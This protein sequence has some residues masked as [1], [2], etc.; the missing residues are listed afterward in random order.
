[1]KRLRP[2]LVSLL[3]GSLL[4]AF[5]APS[6]AA[7]GEILTI[8]NVQ[9]TA[10]LYDVSQY[11]G[12]NTLSNVEVGDLSFGICTPME[13]KPLVVLLKE[14]T[15][16][17]EVTDGSFEYLG[18]EYEY[19]QFNINSFDPY[20]GSL[21]PPYNYISK[22]I[23]V[24]GGVTSTVD[25]GTCTVTSISQ[26]SPGAASLVGG[27]IQYTPPATYKGPDAFNYACKDGTAQPQLVFVYVTVRNQ[28]PVIAGV[29]RTVEPGTMVSLPVVASDPNNDQITLT[30]GTSTPLLVTNLSGNTLQFAVPVTFQGTSTVPVTVTDSEGAKATANFSV[31]VG[32]APVVSGAA[33]VKA[34]KRP[35][36]VNRI[37]TVTSQVSLVLPDDVQGIEITVNGTIAL[38]QQSVSSKTPT[39]PITFAPGDKVE[40]FTTAVVGGNTIKSEGLVLPV[41]GSLLPIA[42]VNFATG[43]SV[44]T[45][46]AKSILDGVIAELQARGYT[47]IDIVG[48]TDS[49]GGTSNIALAKARAAAV[50]MYF[51]DNGV[52]LTISTNAVSDKLPVSSNK[53]SS[54]MAL[55]RRVEVFVS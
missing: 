53:S 9:L 23:I 48:H 49:A 25:H 15:C 28:A 30:S 45:S 6:H 20:S 10:G 41:T 17:L 26:A 14:G 29:S 37:S 13:G 1:M 4:F 24:D 44:L 12:D 31:T 47:S 54:G 21:V 50:K 2:L 36:A 52:T 51:N 18:S 40:A 11:I 7:N 34:S 5:A 42:N 16:T 46:A 39:I 38:S 32:L 43:S 33:T 27:V 8:P 3:A 19:I 22:S 35:L 55:N